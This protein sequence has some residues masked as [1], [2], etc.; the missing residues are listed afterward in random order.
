MMHNLVN[1]ENAQAVVD[2]IDLVNLVCKISVVICVFVVAFPLGLGVSK[3][4]ERSAAIVAS[5][6][7]A[8]TSA[9]CVGTLTVDSIH[10]TYEVD[11]DMRALD[12]VDRNV[13]TILLVL[14]LVMCA[15]TVVVARRAKR[16]ESLQANEDQLVT[17]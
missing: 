13:I 1:A 7:G 6:A 15:A 16:R 14:M 17:D 3:K 10:K 2:A 5:V 9:F 11:V 12:D 4:H 8:I